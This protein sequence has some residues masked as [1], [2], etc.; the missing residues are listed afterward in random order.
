[1][2]GNAGPYNEAELRELG[3]DFIAK[4][5]V[6]DELSVLLRQVADRPG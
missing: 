5:F 4:P 6:L 1:M 3:A 2:S